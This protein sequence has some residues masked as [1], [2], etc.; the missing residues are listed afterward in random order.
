MFR[1]PYYF[2][3]IVSLFV[4]IIS[5]DSQSE[6]VVEENL[7]PDGVTFSTHDNFV[8]KG[9]LVG[10]GEVIVVITHPLEKNQESSSHLDLL[11]DEITKIDVRV[12]TFD[13]RKIE[14]SD[15]SMINDYSSDILSALDYAEQ[16]SSTPPIL[17]GSGLGGGLAFQTSF[18]RNL[19]GVVM[20]SPLLEYSGETIQ[21]GTSKLS[22]P[23]LFLTSEGENNLEI[24]AELFDLA[25]SPRILE[26]YTGSDLGLKILG[27]QH[28]ELAKSRILD[29]IQ[30]CIAGF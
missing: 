2:F 5:C 21:V 29:F 28:T 3:I 10:E 11:I 14:N 18:E 20:I 22:T 30:G 8:L 27:G 24:T 19:L 12:L 6:S 16:N 13:F 1:I 25:L 23:S 7:G 4:L 15:G 26:V 9:R 17:I